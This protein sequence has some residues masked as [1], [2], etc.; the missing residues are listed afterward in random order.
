MSDGFLISITNRNPTIHQVTLFQGSVPSGLTIHTIDGRYNFEQLQ[1]A[2]KANPF[3]GNALTT[4][5]DKEILIEIVNN[6]Q[7][8]KIMLHGRYEGADMI[9]DEQHHH[10]KVWCP[11][12]SIFYIRLHSI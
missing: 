8:E 4:D 6:G 11:A 1:L 2:A 3:K 9:V 12:N 10:I 5:S 7:E